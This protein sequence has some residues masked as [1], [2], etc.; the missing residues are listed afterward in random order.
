MNNSTL[1]Y[2][3]SFSNEDGVSVDHVFTPDERDDAIAVFHSLLNVPFAGFP[4]TDT[5]M[6]FQGYYDRDTA[7][8]GYTESTYREG[9]GGNT[10]VMFAALIHDL[11]HTA[12][13]DN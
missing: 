12:D 3:V 4:E 8:Y 2:N 9:N 6:D 11:F 13:K 10:T 1:S 5:D 7:Q